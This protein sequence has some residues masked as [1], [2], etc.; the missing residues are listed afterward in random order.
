MG[1]WKARS[2]GRPLQLHAE[3]K[4]MLAETRRKE[5]RRLR[6]RRELR[7]P[8]SPFISCLTRII[9]LLDEVVLYGRHIYIKSMCGKH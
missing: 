3:D 8:K 6:E 2:A 5:K 7:R 4:Q 1:V 9:T